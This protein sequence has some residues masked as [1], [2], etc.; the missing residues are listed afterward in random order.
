MSK[1]SDLYASNYVNGLSF[2]KK[3]DFVEIVSRSQIDD[4]ITS[5]KENVGSFLQAIPSFKEFVER[6]KDPC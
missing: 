4:R 6:V 5:L 1:P 2:Q 3:G